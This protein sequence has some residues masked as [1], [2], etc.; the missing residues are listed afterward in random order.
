MAY[1]QQYEHHL[2]LILLVLIISTPGCQSLGWFSSSSTASGDDSGY[3]SGDEYPFSGVAVADFSLDFPAD[4]KRLVEKARDKL[5][6][7]NTCWQNA[8]RNILSGCTQIHADEDKRKRF[9]WHLSDCFQKDSGRRRFPNCNEK[10]AMVHCLKKL[11]D[12]EHKVYLEFFTETNSICYQLQVH[13][14]K[15]ETERLVNELKSSAEYTEQQLETIKD[16]TV[17]LLQNSNQIHD[18]LSSVDHKVQRVFQ[19]SKEV[20][21]Q[22]GTLSKQSEAVYKQSEDIVRSQSELQVGQE[23]MNENLKEGVTMLQDA[24]SSLGEEVSNLRNEAVEIENQI[25]K[26]GE[27]MTSRFQNLQS[28]ADDIENMAGSSLSKQQELLDGQSTA[29]KG[30]E[31]LTESQSA[32]LQESRNAMQHLADLGRQQQEELLERQKQLQQV[33]DHLVSNSKSILEAQEAFEVKQASMFIALDKLFE[34]HNAMLLESRGIKAFFIYT[35][36]I[37][38]IYMVTS[39]KQTYPAR[40]ILYLG[41]STTF[42]LE[43]AI[44]RL[45]PIDL[46]RQT[47]MINLARL[48]FAFLAILKIIHAIYTYRDYEV[49][50]HRN[51]LTLTEKINSMQ[52]SREMSDS[53]SEVEWSRWVD[54]EISEEEVTSLRDPDYMIP[55]AAADRSIVSFP[56]TS[57]YNLR[58]RHHFS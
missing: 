4:N 31:S 38:I 57:N 56:V 50:N 30:L 20:E 17:T 3:A 42:L 32:A 7:S 9:A 51:I 49:L 10:S 27:S 55:G 33:H 44:I 5:V 24:Y 8:Y 14:F 53:D 58:Q 40:A 34:L 19:T 16:R 41:L 28:K 45:T 1:L 11:D 18:S 13:A 6:G 15:R 22:I 2:A 21:D 37:F 29:L 52:R 36:S 25:D 46:E 35:M 54:D 43:L 48:L 12:H 23:K 26:V 39:T 47:W